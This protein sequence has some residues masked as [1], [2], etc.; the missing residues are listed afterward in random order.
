MIY[1]PAAQVSLVREQLNVRVIFSAKQSVQSANQVY[2]IVNMIVDSCYNKSEGYQLWNHLCSLQ[3][4]D[5]M[6]WT[7][8]KWTGRL[9]LIFVLNC[10][11]MCV[12][13]NN[14]PFSKTHTLQATCK[15]PMLNVSNE[16]SN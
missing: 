3:S 11:A 16:T 15:L 6:D 14:Q 12:L 5:C 2:I 7:I 4:L 1:K 8:V 9:M 13:T 10:V